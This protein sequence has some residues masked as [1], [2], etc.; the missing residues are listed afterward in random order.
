MP[1]LNITRTIYD[2]AIKDFVFDS[3][4]S[5]TMPHIKHWI[6]NKN[7]VIYWYVLRIDILSDNP[8][9]Q[10]AVE[11]YTH[12]ALHIVDAYVEGIDRRFELKKGE[13][14]SWSD[15]YVL[16]IPKQLGIPITGRGSRRIFFKVDINCKEGLMHEY[17]ISG[18]FIAQGAEPISI[19]EKTFRYSCK[20]GEFRQIFNNNPDEASIYAKK[21]LS[22]RY[23]SND[24]QLFTNSFRMIHD[25][26][27]YCHSGSLE[28][29]LSN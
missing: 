14:D 4:E 12:Q 6:N 1:I 22:D 16:S 19:R 15:K 20:V 23:S 5:K 7:P 24:I 10:W 13:R 26:Y 18:T 17:S 28:K 8:L 25:L 3:S 9:D 27:S 2:P 21:R 29:R 11:L